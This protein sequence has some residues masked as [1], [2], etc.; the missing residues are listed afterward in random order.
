MGVTPPEGRQLGRVPR[1]RG[2]T[3]T[4]TLA[5]R[6]DEMWW[7]AVGFYVVGDLATTFL[8][9]Q[10][11]GITEIGPVAVILLEAYG[12]GAI[13]GLKLVMLGLFFVLWWSLPDRITIGIP[14]S[15]ACVGVCVTGW[16]VG[17]ILY[18]VLLM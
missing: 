11:V 3:I 5:A 4:G 6:S 18:A 13:T 9:L 16:N 8:G 17:M 10:F 7:T 1:D 15:L 14:L 12:F 2:E